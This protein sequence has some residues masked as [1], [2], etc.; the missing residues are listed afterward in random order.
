MS[1]AVKVLMGTVRLVA[2]GGMKKVP[3]I[4]AIV[5]LDNGSVI[6]IEEEALTELFPAVS[7][8]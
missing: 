3:M 1:V 7:L 2:V 4:G 6:I 5:S 8:T